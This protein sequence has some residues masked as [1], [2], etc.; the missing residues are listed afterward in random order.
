M[1]AAGVGDLQF[2]AFPP[3]KFRKSYADNV[4]IDAFLTVY[5]DSKQR[6]LKMVPPELTFHPWQLQLAS[7]SSEN[8]VF[9]S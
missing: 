5:T 6:A 9:L 7:T 8:V 3:L 1:L 2:A 4:P